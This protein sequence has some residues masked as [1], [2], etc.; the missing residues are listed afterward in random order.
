M[1]R[2]TDEQV[3]RRIEALQDDPRFDRFRSPGARRGVVV[4]TYGLLL[5][6]TV[7][8]LAE[9]RLAALVAGA[10]TAGLILLLRRAVRL[11]ADAPDPAL[12][13]RLIA[14]RDSAYRYAFV[15][16]SAVASM[17][18]LVLFIATD[19]PRFG[20]EP[21]GHHLEALFWAYLGAAIATPS[22]VLAWRER[23]I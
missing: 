21:R 20:F 1:A 9:Q 2:S 11:T 15:G 10:A 7:L 22:A 16:V 19:A 6:A 23:H 14:V 3:R 18:L 5:A 4:A 13:E 12:D 8:L 17:V